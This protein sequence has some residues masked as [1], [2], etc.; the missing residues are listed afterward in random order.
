MQ[1]DMV[2]LAM[3]LKFIHDR[4]QAFGLELDPFQAG[5]FDKGEA[6]LADHGPNHR[7]DHG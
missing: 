7:F 6:V 3:F 2:G 5:Y 4:S 1:P